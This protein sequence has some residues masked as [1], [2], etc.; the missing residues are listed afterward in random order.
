MN[1]NPDA[2]RLSSILRF[3]AMEFRNIYQVTKALQAKAQ[4]QNAGALFPNDTDPIG[5]GADGVLSQPITN[6]DVR[7]FV[8]M[9]QT[10]LNYCENN[11]NANLQT[12]MKIIVK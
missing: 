3:L 7:A 12:F 5:D 9:L 11:T 1:T 6:A 2:V 10:F 4:A 8:G